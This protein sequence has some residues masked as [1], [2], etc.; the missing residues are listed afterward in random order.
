MRIL[1]WHEE[2]KIKPPF[3]VHVLCYC[4]IYGYYIG[5][6]ERIEDTNWGNWH[7]GKQLGVL[8]PIHWME[9]P[10]INID[11]GIINSVQS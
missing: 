6:Y 2:T 9:L 11:T 8:P 5:S 4:K 3:G 10:P 1:N 7:D